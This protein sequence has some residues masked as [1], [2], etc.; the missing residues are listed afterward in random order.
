M[1]ENGDFR[2]ADGKFET[3]ECATTIFH[4]LNDTVE[5]FEVFPNEATDAGIE[6]DCFVS[7]VG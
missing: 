5:V 3:G 2:R 7:S 6:R 1:S 4:A